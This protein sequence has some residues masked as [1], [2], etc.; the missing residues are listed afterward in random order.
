M[1]EQQRWSCGFCGASGWWN[2]STHIG[3][4]P[5]KDH[6]RPQGGRCQKS[7]AKPIV[8]DVFLFD[9]RDNVRSESLGEYGSKDD[10]L[11]AVEDWRRQ[12]LPAFYEVKK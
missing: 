12:G 5:E 8:Y 3:V 2:P 1:N 6:D 9:A 7:R 4:K 10:A 11:L